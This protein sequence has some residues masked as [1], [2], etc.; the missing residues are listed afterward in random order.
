MR[1]LRDV[2]RNILGDLTVRTKQAGSK[3]HP[4]QS[5]PSSSIFLS[6]TLHTTSSGMERSG[7]E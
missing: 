1:L 3:Q 5:V 7:E 6:V 2:M 4:G